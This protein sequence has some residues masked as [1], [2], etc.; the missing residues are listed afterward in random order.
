MAFVGEKWVR[1]ITGNER[2]YF[3]WADLSDEL[4]AAG[5]LSGSMRLEGQIRAAIGDDGGRNAIQV[6]HRDEI[7]DGTLSHG[8]DIIG[9]MARVPFWSLAVTSLGIAALLAASARSGRREFETM[10]AVG[11]TRGQLRRLLTGEGMLT[12]LCAAALGVLGGGLAGWSFTG[13]SR[14]MMSA[15][16]AV[17]LSVPWCMVAEGVAFELALCLLMGAVGAWAA[18]GRRRD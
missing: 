2:T 12:G 6:H 11:M 5:G 7:A 17:K 3:L 9:T 10:R 16:L 4:R 1:E 13:I 14:W 18:T 15:G 8:N